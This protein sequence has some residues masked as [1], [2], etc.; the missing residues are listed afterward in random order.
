MAAPAVAVD[1]Y[2]VKAF[3]EYD[4]DGNGT[5]D[6]TE[7]EA[8]LTGLGMPC[9]PTAVA[10]L[11]ASFSMTGTL[12]LEQFDGV[13]KMLQLARKMELSKKPLTPEALEACTCAPT[14]PRTI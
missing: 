10:S 4:A 13:V 12:T 1:A 7:L 2:V 3:Q 9:D 6:A 5:M 8:A 14:S 11:I